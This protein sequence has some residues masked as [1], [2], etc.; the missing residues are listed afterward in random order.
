MS[1]RLLTLQMEAP[2]SSLSF[3]T[4][5]TMNVLL[6]SLLPA[7]FV[8]DEG[9]TSSARCRLNWFTL[10]EKSSLEKSNM[11]C[12]SDEEESHQTDRR[13]S[14]QKEKLKYAGVL[15]KG[16]GRM[17]PR[18]RSLVLSNEGVVLVGDGEERV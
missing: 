11:K 17:D 8:W 2:V 18:I 1:D 12:S 15:F 14:P 4:G 13:T 9:E 7:G 5:L 10:V 3:I 16:D 6:C